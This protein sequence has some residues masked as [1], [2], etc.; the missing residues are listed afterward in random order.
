MERRR[1]PGRAARSNFSA[2]PAV[3]YLVF[4][5]ADFQG[6]PWQKVTA[7]GFAIDGKEPFAAA[8]SGRWVNHKRLILPELMPAV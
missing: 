7:V 3:Y 5:Q 8:I 6:T 4:C 1:R 2:S